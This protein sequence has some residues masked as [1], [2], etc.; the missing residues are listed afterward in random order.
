MKIKN[1]LL[2]LVASTSVI[3]SAS[4]G[5]ASLFQLNKNKVNAEMNQL[6]QVENYVASHEG[7]T[8][9]QLKAENSDIINGINLTE[10]TST[11]S[12]LTEGALGIPSFI[13]GCVLGWVGI[14]I[15][16]L[17]TQDSDETKKALY[18]CLIG[19][20]GGFL[21]YIVFVV[22]IFGGTAFWSVAD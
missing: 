12:A 11:L 1:L 22:L 21:L 18:G 17:V 7:V 9:T 5:N 4:A 20:V 14:L 2:A 13:W 6:S 10:S 3:L 8:L 19:W 16:Y 15:T